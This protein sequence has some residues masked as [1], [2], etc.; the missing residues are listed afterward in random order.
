M[1]INDVEAKSYLMLPPLRAPISS[2]P[3]AGYASFS[4]GSVLDRSVLAGPTEVQLQQFRTAVNILNLHPYNPDEDESV[5]ED[6]PIARDASRPGRNVDS[7]DT[8]REG[9]KDS[10]NDHDGSGSDPVASDE[11]TVQ[12]SGPARGVD[13]DIKTGKENG[14]LDAHV[15]VSL[16]QVSH[17]SYP[18]EGKNGMACRDAQ[19]KQEE[20]WPQ[21]MILGCGILECMGPF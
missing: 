14:S 10:D 1:I 17:H 9:L 16:G 13:S 18:R 7:E 20:T 3:A 19:S 6:K 4:V 11:A 5:F 2:G 8:N 21:L 15:S 12:G